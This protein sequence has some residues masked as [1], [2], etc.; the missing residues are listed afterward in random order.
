M[1][2]EDEADPDLQADGNM[3]AP[4]PPVA[5]TK[6]KSTKKGK[7]AAK[8]GQVKGRRV[9]RDANLRNGGNPRNGGIILK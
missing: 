7:A 6:K 5:T 8:V 9:V 4:V 3:P 1:I 2:A